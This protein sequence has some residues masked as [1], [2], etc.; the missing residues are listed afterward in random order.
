MSNLLN[1]FE[2]FNV[3]HES[4]VKELKRSYYQ[5]AM[6]CHPDKG[7]EAEAMVTI[8]KAYKYVLEQLE[9]KSDKS[10]EEIE[11][12]FEQFCKQQ[13]EIPMP[14]YNSI[15]DELFEREIM[16][17][18]KDTNVYY[19]DAFRNH[20]YG[21]LMEESKPRDENEPNQIDNTPIRNQFSRELV[22]YKE[23][24]ASPFFLDGYLN[25]GLKEVNDFSTQGACDY[26]KAFCCSS[27]SET[28]LGSYKEKTY[29]ELI[30][31]REEFNKNF[32]IETPEEIA[33]KPFIEQENVIEE[34]F[35][36]DQISSG[37]S[38]T[39]RNDDLND[40]S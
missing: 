19:N 39:F 31:E 28:N 13:L 16:S 3:T 17:I 40:I 30:K 11:L 26:F 1:P 23:P 21:H 10:Y 7:G 29:D 20:G 35:P 22:E 5:L 2:L 6:M 15:T 12:E 34:Y 37:S 36:L 32:P 33:I 24:S 8:V 4:T 14:S 27:T 9:H 25:L 18:G 38:C